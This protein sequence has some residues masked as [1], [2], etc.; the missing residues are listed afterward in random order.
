MENGYSFVFVGDFWNWSPKF[1]RQPLTNIVNTLGF[2]SLRLEAKL[3]S[4]T[5]FIYSWTDL[6][7][8]SEGGFQCQTHCSHCLAYAV[9]CK[10]WLKEGELMVVACIV[11][12]ES[13]FSHLNLI[14]DSTDFRSRWKYTYSCKRHRRPKPTAQR[15]Q[16]DQN[17]KPFYPGR[18]HAWGSCQWEQI[19]KKAKFKLQQKVIHEEQTTGEKGK[20][21]K[22]KI[23]SWRRTSLQPHILAYFLKWGFTTFLFTGVLFWKIFATTWIYKLNIY[24]PVKSTPRQQVLL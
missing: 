5:A 23:R 24:G 12:F 21:F 1:L 18:A 13:M 7:F 11:P 22:W 20:K 9:L 2:K 19:V 15:R 6:L 16:R 17:S 14:K 3:P 4:L 8:S 10:L